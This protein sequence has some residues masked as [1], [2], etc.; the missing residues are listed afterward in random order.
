[1]LLMWDYIACKGS[2][3]A[4]TSTSSAPVAGTQDD[5]TDI[6]RPKK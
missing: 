4:H 2:E 6:M 1:M 5:R 3:G